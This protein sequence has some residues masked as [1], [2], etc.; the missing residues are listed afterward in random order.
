MSDIAIEFDHVSK[1]FKLGERAGSLRDFVPGIV[2]RLT[3]QN[4]QTEGPKDFWALKDVSFQILQRSADDPDAIPFQV[5][6]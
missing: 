5:G 3:G 1:R 4:G 2:R 6:L